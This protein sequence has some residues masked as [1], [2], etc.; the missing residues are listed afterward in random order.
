MQ[1]ISKSAALLLLLLLATACSDSDS[2][3]LS[4]SVGSGSAALTAGSVAGQWRLSS[5]QPTGRAEQA[6]PAG[7]TYT[8]TLTDDRA[9]LTVDCNV[10]G[11]AVAVTGGSMTIG[12][13]LACTLAACP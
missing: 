4:P 3:P 9:S 13:R 11:G 6:A 8:M 5:M 1:V 7:A 12:P 2:N 10:C